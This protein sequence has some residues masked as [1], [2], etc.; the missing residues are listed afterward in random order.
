MYQK[1][2]SCPDYDVPR[3]GFVNGASLQANLQM[4]ACFALCRSGKFCEKFLAAD[5]FTQRFMDYDLR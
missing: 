3:H 1:C 5:R 4:G 2:K